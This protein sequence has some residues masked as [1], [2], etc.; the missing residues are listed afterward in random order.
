VPTPV[1][2]PNLNGPNVYQNGAAA[3]DLSY[4]SYGFVKVWLLTP[5]SVRI[6]VGIHTGNDP[7]SNTYYYD[8]KTDGSTEIY[9]LQMGSGSYSVSVYQLA[10]NGGYSTIASTNADVSLSS[11]L[12]PY[13]VPNQFVNYS[14]GSQAVAIARSIVS[15]KSN[16]YERISAV[17]SYVASHITYDYNLASTVQSGY[18]PNI[19]ADLASGKGIC[20]DYAAISAA[21]LRSLG[22]PTK[23]VIGYVENGAVYHAWN[24]VYIEGQGWVKVMSVTLNTNRWSRVDVTFIS[25]STSPATI[26]KYIGNDSNYQT[27]LTY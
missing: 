18:I 20:F 8:L 5:S 1:D 26:A 17:L 13:L 4:I 15:G 2:I 21:M 22:Y 6:K 25:S 14:S 7:N 16:N 9:P 23:L 19:D 12:A 11:S 24:E 3:I 10:S 27:V